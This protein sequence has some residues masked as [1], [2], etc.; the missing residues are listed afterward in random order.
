[1]SKKHRYEKQQ[2]N[3]YYSINMQ[4]LLCTESLASAVICQSFWCMDLAALYVLLCQDRMPRARSRD[5][6]IRASWTWSISSTKFECD[7][8]ELQVFGVCGTRQNFYVFSLYASLTKTAWCV[9]C[10]LLEFVTASACWWGWENGVLSDLLPD[11]F[12]SKQCR[13][14]AA[15]SLWQ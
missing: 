12:D 3:R 11:H 15:R 1:M 5:D 14:S 8:C 13:E 10:V 2:R 9:W 4:T 6:Y 7:R